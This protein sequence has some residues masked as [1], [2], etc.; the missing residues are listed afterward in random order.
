MESFVA[1]S[2]SA[3]GHA[4]AL[5]AGT[6]AACVSFQEL[7]RAVGAGL[8]SEDAI[9]AAARRY[10]AARLV[11][12]IQNPLPFFPKSRHQHGLDILVLMLVGKTA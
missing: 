2:S 9:D 5:M 3:E 1:C 7:P 10:L 12:C 11:H 4:A 8:V 6:D